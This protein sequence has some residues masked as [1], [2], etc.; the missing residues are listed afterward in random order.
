MQGQVGSAAP[1][2]QPAAHHQP[3]QAAAV[4]ARSYDEAKIQVRLTNG[5]TLVQVKKK[6]KILLRM[7][8]TWQIGTSFL[9]SSFVIGVDWIES[10]KVIS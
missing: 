1:P 5:K 8:F 3:V 6:L 10:F 9:I 2:A 7:D 4:P